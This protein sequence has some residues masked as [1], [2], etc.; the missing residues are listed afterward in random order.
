VLADEPTGA[1]DSASTAEVL[2][3]FQGLHQQGR[4]VVVITHEHDVAERA[5]RVIRLRDGAVIEDSGRSPTAAAR[6]PL[7]A[8]GH[9]R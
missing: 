7:V 8:G 2:G 6:E 9:A 4:T 1:L 3:M 5:G